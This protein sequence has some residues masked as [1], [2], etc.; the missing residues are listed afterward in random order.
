VHGERGERGGWRVRRGSARAS[1]YTP[2]YC[3]L[4]R[5]CD[6]EQGKIAY[7]L[8]LA[9]TNVTK[10]VTDVGFVGMPGPSYVYIHIYTYIYIIIYMYT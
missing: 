2:P 1:P 8:D 6:Q 3:G 5:G 4:Y 10:F 9:N 7:G